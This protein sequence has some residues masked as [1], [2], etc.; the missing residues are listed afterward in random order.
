MFTD[1]S[2]PFIEGIYGRRSPC[3][4]RSCQKG[5]NNL[6]EEENVK[7]SCK[8]KGTSWGAKGAI[9]TYNLQVPY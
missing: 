3:L 6:K 9:W 2:L 8:T 4:V 5:F 1:I 7:Y